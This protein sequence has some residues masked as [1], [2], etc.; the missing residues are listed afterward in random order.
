FFR[1]VVIEA[2]GD[3]KAKYAIDALIAI[4]KL[5]GPL[6]DDAAMALGKIGDRRALETLAG[7][8]RTASRN[9]QPSISAAMGLIGIN[10][11]SQRTYLGDTMKFAG[12]NPGFQELLRGAAASLGVLA[13]AGQ[14]EALGTLFEI[15]LP[16]K[17]DATRAPVALA[18]ATV[19]LR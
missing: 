7:L 11:E 5:D 18:V 13:V 19:A 6:Q 2:L 3:Y 15:G 17:D 10:C 9:A 1:S 8:Q 4:V 16:A 12:K 14:P